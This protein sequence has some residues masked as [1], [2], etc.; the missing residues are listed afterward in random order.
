MKQ[1]YSILSL[2]LLSVFFVSCNNL[3][4]YSESTARERIEG[5]W[6]VT[7]VKNRVKKDGK[8]GKNDVS[9]NYKDWVFTFDPGGYSSL[10][11]PQDNTT[12]QGEWEVY[13]SVEFN[14]D[15][16]A[17][18]K[19]NLWMIYWHPDSVNAYVEFYWEDMKVSQSTFKAQEDR[20]FGDHEATYF[21][22]LAR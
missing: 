14:D 6:T 3:D 1:F 21:F 9:S 15:G 2:F 13:E 18:D 19:M 11:V 5:T 4:N 16:E 8:W 12:Y 10:Y 22:E 7:G 17:T 20:T